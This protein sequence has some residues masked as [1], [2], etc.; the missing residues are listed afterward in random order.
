MH[1]IRGS[2]GRLY[3]LGDPCRFAAPLVD[4]GDGFDWRTADPAVSF[5]TEEPIFETGIGDGWLPLEPLVVYRPSGRAAFGRCLAGSRL[6]AT[7]VCLPLTLLAEAQGWELRARVGLEVKSDLGS[8]HA[9]HATQAEK[10]F[11]RLS[12]TTAA[13]RVLARLPF[14]AGMFV[15]CGDST[16]TGP[17]S[18][19]ALDEEGVAY[20]P[21]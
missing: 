15:G 14:Q 7:G 19:L 2:G 13:G 17:D 5:W 4:C 20:V 9:V 11:V 8:D 6:R 16:A 21:C 1:V 18:V 12:G 10:Q 3:R